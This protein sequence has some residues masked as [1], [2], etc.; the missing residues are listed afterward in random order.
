LRST[1][2]ILRRKLTDFIV[3]RD[4]GS[5]TP[6]GAESEFLGEIGDLAICGASGGENCRFA[7]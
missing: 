7:S 3:R 2:T 5:G 6:N 1:H 4:A